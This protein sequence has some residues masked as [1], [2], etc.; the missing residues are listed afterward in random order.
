MPDLPPG[1]VFDLLRLI[2]F[3]VAVG[4]VATACRSLLVRHAR[5]RGSD[6]LGGF[7]A[8]PPGTFLLVI[9]SFVV[10]L[11]AFLVIS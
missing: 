10:C 1:F 9:M 8:S 7:V 5:R 2:G 3:M 4:V 11:L 6:G